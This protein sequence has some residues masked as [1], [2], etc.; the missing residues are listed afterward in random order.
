MVTTLIVVFDTPTYEG[1]NPC[2]MI[3]F[4]TQERVKPD[5]FY[6]LHHYIRGIL[7]RSLKTRKISISFYI[8]LCFLIRLNNFNIMYIYYQNIDRDFF[9]SHS[10]SINDFYFFGYVQD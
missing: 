7:V 1:A 9:P 8:Y 2:N 5:I 3:T 4:D 6:H 10:R